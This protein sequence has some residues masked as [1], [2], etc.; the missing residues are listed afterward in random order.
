MGW[1]GVGI[2]T[3]PRYIARGKAGNDNGRSSAQ[4]LEVTQVD[5]CNGR[6]SVEATAVPKQAFDVLVALAKQGALFQQGCGGDLRPLKL[7][8]DA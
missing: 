4:E 8:V 2:S 3:R 5:V 6:Y 1:G 7:L